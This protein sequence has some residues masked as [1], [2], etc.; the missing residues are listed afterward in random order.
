M[1]FYADISWESRRNIEINVWA[2]FYKILL[3]FKVPYQ[4]QAK[5]MLVKSYNDQKLV[6]DTSNLANYFGSQIDGIVC[7]KPI[8]LES[9]RTLKKY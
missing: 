7:V 4:P 6:K 1:G 8:G 9:A 3:D 2:H 5:G